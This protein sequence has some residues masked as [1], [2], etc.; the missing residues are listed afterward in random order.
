MATNELRMTHAL[1]RKIIQEAVTVAPE[2]CCGLLIGKGSAV[3]QSE[4]LTNVADDPRS[5]YLAEPKELLHALFRAKEKQLELLAIYHSHPRGDTLPSERDIRE[6]NYP[7]AAQLIIG[8][9]EKEAELAVWKID[10]GIVRAV[11]LR[12]TDHLERQPTENEPTRPLLLFLGAL[13]TFTLTMGLA[14]SALT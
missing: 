7:Q 2:E 10:Q 14:I 12:F 13:I 11:P 8:L 1:A 5:E 3:F 9:G 4:P 6:A